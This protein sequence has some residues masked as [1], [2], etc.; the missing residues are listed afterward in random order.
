MLYFAAEVNEKS[1]EVLQ[2]LREVPSE[3]FD[4]INYHRL[5]D[6]V[7][8][9]C[10]ALSGYRFFYVTK[11]MILALAGTILTYELVLLQQRSDI[12]V[13]HNVTSNACGEM[14]I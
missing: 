10:V 1:R 14:T 5:L 2:I 12:D 13:D 11:S 8:S 9:N 6:V 4:G 3:T 7:H